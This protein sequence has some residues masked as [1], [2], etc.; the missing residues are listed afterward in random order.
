MMGQIALMF[1]ALCSFLSL[2]ILLLGEIKKRKTNSKDC[3]NSGKQESKKSS[4][5]NQIIGKTKT[6]VG[7]TGT[8]KDKLTTNC[9]HVTKEYSFANN[10][11]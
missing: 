3:S 10:K 5:V 8:I 11:Q 4:S 2:A 7:Q 6:I 9:Q 1:I